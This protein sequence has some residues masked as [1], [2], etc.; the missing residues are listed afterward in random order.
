M[1]QNKYYLIVDGP[2]NYIP[3]SATVTKV[4]PFLLMNR[5]NY[6]IVF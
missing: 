5:F 2:L 3:P 6:M 4:A 1:R